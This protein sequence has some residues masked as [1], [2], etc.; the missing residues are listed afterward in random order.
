MDRR[1]HRA[2]ILI[3]IALGW[4]TLIDAKRQFAL[5]S[6]AENVAR[7]AHQKTLDEVARRERLESQL[8]QSQKMEAVGQLTGGIAHD[9][10]NMLAVVGSL[11]LLKRRLLRGETDNMRFSKA[12][13][14]APNARR[15]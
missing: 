4:L 13:L 11:N 9:F 12:R 10:N 8:R 15:L 5:A 1:R 6:A 3:T 14:T 7:A 2:A